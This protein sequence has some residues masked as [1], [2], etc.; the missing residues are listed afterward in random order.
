LIGI[1]TNVLV[2]FLTLHDAEQAALAVGL[3]D[4]LTA[5]DPAFI[6]RQ[7]LIQTV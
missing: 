1:D 4:T 2:R 6:S 7:V 3:I 5:Q